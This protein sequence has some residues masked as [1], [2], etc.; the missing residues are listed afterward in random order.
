MHNINRSPLFYVGDK[1]KLIREIKAFFPSR[2]TRFVEP[3]VGGGSAFLNVI[4]ERY[5]LNDNNKYVIS[6]H[7]F[8]RDYS[9]KTQQF[10]NQI[11][12]LIDKY[13]LSFS[14]IRNDIPIELRTMFFKTY[15][16]RYNKSGYEKLR[17]DYN[18]GGCT[19]NMLLYL[20]LIYGFNH[21]IR[22]NRNGKFNLPVGNVDFNKNVKNA[23]D[24]YFNIVKNC[25]IEWKCLDFRDFFENNHFLHDDFFYIDP[26]YLITFSE[27]NKFWTETEERNLLDI[28]DSL[29][30][31]GFKFA[32]SNVTRYKG[33]CNKIFLNW[34]HRYNIH[35]IKSNYISYHDNT[36]KQL[37]EILVTNY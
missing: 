18:E 5:L 2:I 4:A 31:K 1:Y 26:P 11:Q 33:K 14:L 23:L 36:I 28:L 3:F 12:A 21:M 8:L 27:Y 34:A 22:F 17:A 7:K 15:Y 30:K 37:N 16:A 19:D 29:D 13:E 9:K 32:I 20:L 10:Y 25:K 35:P 6:L 24:G